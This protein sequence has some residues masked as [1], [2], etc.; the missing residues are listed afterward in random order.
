M[1]DWLRKGDRPLWLGITLLGAVLVLSIMFALSVATPASASEAAP[2]VTMVEVDGVRCVVF[3]AH[4]K[5]G[6]TCDW[7]GSRQ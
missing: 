1:N 5:G 6:V 3:D 7:E 4:N 2:S